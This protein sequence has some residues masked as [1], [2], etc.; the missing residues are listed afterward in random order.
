[1]SSSKQ[2]KDEIMEQNRILDEQ[3]VL[4]PDKERIEINNS[5][6]ERV[7]GLFDAQ[8]GV[9]VT[10]FVKGNGGQIAF[11][12]LVPGRHYDV[13]VIGGMSDDKPQFAIA[14]AIGMRDDTDEILKN[15]DG[16]PISYPMDYRIKDSGNNGVY[17]LVDDRGAKVG[18]V[19][20]LT[21]QDDKP[22]FMYI[23]SFKMKDDTKE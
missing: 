22:E 12:N 16:L 2:R 23:M 18:Q 14:W 6:M 8:T 11:N 4:N 13:G 20:Q 3:V 1:M 9:Q 17:D 7:Y 21:Q 5:H 19:A 15:S 10:D